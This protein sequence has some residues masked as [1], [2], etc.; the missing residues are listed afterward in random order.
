MK[1]CWVFSCDVRVWGQWYNASGSAWMLYDNFHFVVVAQ[2]M[3]WPQQVERKSLGWV[4]FSL[5]GEL[6]SFSWIALPLAPLPALVF[7][8]VWQAEQ[9]NIDE[10]AEIAPFPSL[11]YGSYRFFLEWQR[12]LRTSSLV[13]MGMVSCVD[14]STDLL[15]PSSECK[16]KVVAEESAVVLFRVENDFSGGKKKQEFEAAQ[17]NAYWHVLGFL[18]HFREWHALFCSWILYGRNLPWYLGCF[19]G[20]GK[21]ELKKCNWRYSASLSLPSLSALSSLHI[22][23]LDSRIG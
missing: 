7:H 21:S 20:K 19:Q 1:E 8:W 17:I 5:S 4:Q 16:D 14:G 10:I 6:H 2:Q 11:S 12:V 9:Q 18:L 22:T 23:T 3:A 15:Y 13:K